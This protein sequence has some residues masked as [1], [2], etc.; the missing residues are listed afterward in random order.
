MQHLL[1]TYHVLDPALLITMATILQ[2]H[3]YRLLDVTR[4]HLQNDFYHIS[5]HSFYIK[6]SYVELQIEENSYLLLF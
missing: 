1:Q 6:H 4:G 3:G 2:R 5:W